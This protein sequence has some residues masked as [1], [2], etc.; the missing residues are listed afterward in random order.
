[1]SYKL[2]KA[3][4]AA[5]ILCVVYGAL[6]TFGALGQVVSLML[7]N[8]GGLEDAI[9]QHIIDVRESDLPAF[10]VVLIGSIVLSLIESVTLL[11][12]GIGL[13][14]LKHWAKTGAIVAAVVSIISSILG[15]IYYFAY[16]Y[17][18]T[19][20]AFAGMPAALDRQGHV[21]PPGL[22]QFMEIWV[23]FV[24]IAAVVVSLLMIVLMVVIIVLLTRSHV[25]EAFANRIPADLEDRLED[26]ED[27]L[28]DERA[29]QERRRRRR[30]ERQEYDDDRGHDDR[31]GGDPDDRYRA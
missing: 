12:S 13:F 2:P 17:P 26:L 21:A 19:R 31:R 1:M 8:M 7:P 24:E 15:A 23:I 29:E 25:A 3:V 5:A 4:K 22:L 9:Q 6:F 11:V 30:A 14:S 28:D 18:S 27:D 10:Q 16:T 20:K